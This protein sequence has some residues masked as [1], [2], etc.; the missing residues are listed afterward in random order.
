M[1]TTASPSARRRTTPDTPRPDAV[2]DEH[3][4]Q[5]AEQRQAIRVAM[6]DRGHDP[7][8]PLFED[9][10]TMGD[11]A[12][13]WRRIS[14]LEVGPI[15]GIEWMQRTSQRLGLSQEVHDN[16]WRAYD[17]QVR[18]ELDHGAYWGE[19]YFLLTGLAAEEMPWDGDGQ[20]GSNV[21]IAVPPEVEDPAEAR[22]SVFI[23]SAFGL[24][25]ESAFAEVSYPALQKMLRRS[26]LPLAQSFLPLLRQIGRDEARHLA[27]HRYAFHHLRDAD[28]AN[29]VETFM[30]VCNAGRRAFRVPELTEARFAK[31]VGREAPPVTDQI[32]GP[33]HLR[34]A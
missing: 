11:I 1:A 21:N 19:L 4:N 5:Y 18:D 9:G 33:D 25:L 29:T 8:Q 26:D 13:Q 17:R 34:V 7:D 22:R 3:A 24:G 12:D 31:H 28:P 23:G 27:I 20:G 16:L 30:S 6:V 15:P 2:A 10:P 14:V 32:L